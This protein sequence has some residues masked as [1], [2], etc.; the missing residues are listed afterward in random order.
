MSF[1]LKTSLK[2]LLINS[3]LLAFNTNAFALDKITENIQAVCLSPAQQGKY[4]DVTIKGGINAD[5]S[6]RLIALGINGE[7]TFTKGEWDGLQRVLKEHQAGD[8]DSYRKCVIE[9]MPFFKNKF[10]SKTTT[11][12]SAAKTSPS[13][14]A[15]V[16]KSDAKEN[17]HNTQTIGNIT[18]D[19][20]VNVNEINGDLNMGGK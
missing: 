1:T 7:A 18:A 11:K 20:V 2:A 8:N 15:S 5:G 10:A 9:V 4:W 13:S 16:I 17:N 6:V 3:L 14:K 19:K 12:K